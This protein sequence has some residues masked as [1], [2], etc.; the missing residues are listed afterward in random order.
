MPK[1]N[2]VDQFRGENYIYSYIIKGEMPPPPVREGGGVVEN[3]W[4]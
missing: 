4:T 1:I 2:S 3:V